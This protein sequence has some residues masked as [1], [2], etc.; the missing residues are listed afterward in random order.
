MALNDQRRQ[1]LDGIVQKMISNKE[2]DSNVQAV[3]SDF[4]GK[5]KNEPVAAVN[6]PAMADNSNYFDRVKNNVAA[7]LNSRVDRTG[8]I[9]AR[10]TN[11]LLKGV[12]LFGQGAG[13][14]ANTAESV[15]G[16]LP[17]V[18]P[19]LNAFG[20]GVNFLENSFPVKQI[21]NAIGSSKT[22]Q[23]A[24]S[25]YDNNPNV[26]DTV[27]AVGNTFR[28]YGDAA[29][30]ND[31][32]TKIATKLSQPGAV[33]VGDTAVQAKLPIDEAA[34]KLDFYKKE[35]SSPE[36]QS[37]LTPDQLPEA[38]KHASTDIGASLNKVQP[39]LG[40][41]LIS[42]SPNVKSISEFS[43][44]TQ[45]LIDSSK[46]SDLVSGIAGLVTTP[47]KAVI[48]ATADVA[49]NTG[50]GVVKYAISQATGLNPE[51]ISEILRNPGKFKAATTE[52][53]VEVANAVKEG[54]DN[55]LAELSDVGKNYDAIRNTPASVFIK[56][57]IVSDVLKKYGVKLDAEGKIIT[58]PESRP[59]SAGD[60]AGIQD[61]IDNYGQEPVLSN[62]GFLNAREKLSQLSKYD[63][64]R[65]NLSQSIARDLRSEYDKLGKA[66]IKGLSETDAVY[67]PERQLLGQLKKDLFDANGALKDNAIS[68][69]ANVTGKGKEKLLARMEEIVPDI[70]ERINVLKAA[71]DIERA[72]G[73]KVGTYTRTAV[74]VGGLF[75]GNIPLIIGAIISQPQI[76]VQLLRGAGYV[77]QKVG[78]I[79]DALKAISNDVNN[80][81]FPKPFLDNN[82]N[83]K[84]G[85]S[86]QHSR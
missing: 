5:Y 74:G 53:R 44:L 72:N 60:R 43:D 30:A 82:G 68:K 55:R 16:E 21:G 20:K 85:L 33:N 34:N 12:Q 22:L 11:P 62:N 66:Q 81:R 36:A 63:A 73:L 37:L 57:N 52:S 24:V 19:L 42:A 78:P 58:T 4:V 10:N 35:F 41:K 75:S 76:A 59:L 39:G 45:K 47:A 3:V 28:L 40:D 71:E 50:K 6:Q 67:A 7:D 1:Q 79:I 38:I 49:G 86:M 26:K 31:I 9:L 69:I 18:K 17:V 2:P 8:S 77:G 84:A 14:A 70:K 32:G 65:T 29:L 54:L 83:L 56:P 23:N 51:T 25:A 48:G 64:T 13:L 15:V 61:F 27:D 46:P 80:F